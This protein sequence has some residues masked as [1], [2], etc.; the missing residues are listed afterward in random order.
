VAVL[1]VLALVGAAV[2]VAWPDHVRGEYGFLQTLP[3]GSPYRW[4]PCQP[5]HYEVNLTYAPPGVLSDVREAVSRVSDAT[6]IRFVYDGTTVR[7]TDQQIGAAFQSGIPGQP[8]WL[9]LL[10]EWVPHDHFDYLVDTTQAAAFGYPSSGDGSLADEY[11][12]GVVAVDAG[13][14][15]PSGFAGRYSDG[16]VLMHELG[17]V[18]GLAHVASGHELMW[19][20]TVGGATQFPNL[21]QSDWGPGDLE[22]LKLLGKSSGCLPA[23]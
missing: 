9:P 14:P 11:V 23:R 15:M 10:I 21:A 22:G 4:N 3:D 12:S 2:A 1:L 19:S 6:G 5:I 7:T 17:H 16:V 18:M 8:R 20:P 13:T